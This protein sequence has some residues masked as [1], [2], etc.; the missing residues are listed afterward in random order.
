MKGVSPPLHVIEVPDKVLLDYVHLVLDGEFL[1][2]LN[3][4]INSQSDYGF[5]SNVKEEVDEAM[6]EVKFPHDFNHTLRILVIP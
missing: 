5:L 1:R 3:I 6:V 4:W 2:R